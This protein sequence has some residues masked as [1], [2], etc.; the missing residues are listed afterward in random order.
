MSKPKL[1]RENAHPICYGCG[2]VLKEQ[3][4][5][6][7]REN[8]KPQKGPLCETCANEPRNWR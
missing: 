5:Q 1:I 6:P 7:V 4:M 3:P 2:H 8:G